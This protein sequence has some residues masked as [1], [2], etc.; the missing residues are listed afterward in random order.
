MR[1]SR[2]IS[3]TLTV[4]LAV[5]AVAL[6]VTDLDELSLVSLHDGRMLSLLLNEL[7]HPGRL[8]AVAVLPANAARSIRLPNSQSPA[9]MSQI[10]L[11]I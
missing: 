6:K 11:M 9:S 2:L 7:A 1:S 3:W 4:A 8:R 10:F 5:I